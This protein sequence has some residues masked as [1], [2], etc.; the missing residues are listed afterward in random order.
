MKTIKIEIPAG[1]RARAAICVILARLTDGTVNAK[2]RE[3]MVC[4]MDI[5][6][7]KS[8]EFEAIYGVLKSARDVNVIAQ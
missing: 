7:A 5:E 2:V 4:E 3:D 8:D 6:V 1:P